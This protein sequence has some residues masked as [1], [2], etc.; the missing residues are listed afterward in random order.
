MNHSETMEHPEI[1]QCGKKFRMLRNSISLMLC[2]GT[3]QNQSGRLD[4]D[5]CQLN[6]DDLNY[7]DGS[8]WMLQKCRKTGNYFIVHVGTN[9]RLYSNKE[10]NE[11]GLHPYICKRSDEYGDQLWHIDVSDKGLKF[12]NDN[13]DQKLFLRSFPEPHIGVSDGDEEDHYFN[14]FLEGVRF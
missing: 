13:N 10:R 1:P 6:T 2:Q 8:W 4:V 12:K 5:E 14:I 11:I 7:S 3:G 9:C